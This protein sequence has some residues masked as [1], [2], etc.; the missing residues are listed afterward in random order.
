MNSK[1]VI[2]FI[3]LISF[4]VSSAQKNPSTNDIKANP[5]TERSW[6]VDISRINQESVDLSVKNPNTPEEAPLRSPLEILADLKLLDAE[7]NEILES[8]KELL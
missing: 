2:T 1:L 5:E 7:T 4:L 8:I 6:V 3:F